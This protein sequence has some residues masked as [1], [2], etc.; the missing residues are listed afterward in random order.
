MKI[1]NSPVIA[2]TANRLKQNETQMQKTMEKLSSGLAIKR[3]S[4]NAGGLAVSETMRAQV[5]GTS[6]AQR[7]MQD[8]LSVLQAAD[9]G[10]NHVNSLL[11][12]VR[13]LSVSSANDTLT[14]SDR[15]ANQLELEQLMESINDTA[16]KLQFNTQKILSKDTS[17]SLQIGA[18][19]GQSLS[20]NL[21]DTS[22][23]ALGLDGVSLESQ[24]QA[25]QLLVK[26]DQAIEKVNT[27]LTKIGSEYEALEHHITNSFLLES[28][29]TKSLSMIQ[30]ADIA[31][32]TLQFVSLNIR[33][34]SD[35]LLISSVDTNTKDII[36]LFH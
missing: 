32:E 20:I 18:H 7:N 22:T 28:N 26:V 4:D 10:L 5:R 6:Q 30:D 8:G 19:A 35:K 16:E 13:E 3:A 34:N 14:T 21:V 31:K 36:K 17:L 15:E 23:T 27:H 29:L 24:L 12:R 33:Q 2:S 1:Y 9:G 25:E 11:Q